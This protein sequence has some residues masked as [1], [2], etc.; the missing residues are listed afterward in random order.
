[1]IL[2]TGATGRVGG[3]VVRMLRQAGAEVRCLVRM[4]SEYF[5]LNDT[6]ASYFFGDLRDVQSLRRAV[7]GCEFV[8]HVAG[9]R[10]ESTEN[11]HEV[12]TYQGSLNLIQ[13]AHTEGVSR[14]VMVSCLGA[15][16]G[17]PV[18]A[19]DCL[20]K[21][22]GALCESGLAYTILRP[23]PFLDDLGALVRQSASGKKSVFWASGK[24]QVRPIT[25]RDTAIYAMACLDHPSTLNAIVPLSGAVSATG[26][27]LISSLSQ[28]AGLSPETVQYRGGWAAARAQSLVLGRR[29][30]NRIAQERS[31]WSGEHCVDSTA[32]V[33]AIGIPLQPH[34]EA[35]EAVLNEAHP[36]EDPEARDH[37]VVHRQFQ[38]T[39]YSPGEI[40]ESELPDGPIKL[41]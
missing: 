34:T 18:A 7:E 33:E 12:T 1:M 28:Q 41:I 35:L 26:Q 15:G 30:S 23:G 31:L 4:G 19:F 29:W 3:N 39:V 9:L 21:A 36:S 32:W 24:E 38:A 17:H 6:G 10:M 16:S 8:V 22:E 11:H 2:V 14:F 20:E 5:W 27:E 25:T 13:A 40:H 37:R